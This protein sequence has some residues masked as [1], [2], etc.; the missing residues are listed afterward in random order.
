MPV[1]RKCRLLFGP[2]RAP[3]LHVGDVAACL[4]RDGDVRIKGWSEGRIPWPQGVPGGGRSRPTLLVDDE[5]ARAVRNESA[6]AVKF[7]WGV[8]KKSLWRWRKALGV[9]RT[10]SEGSRR[11]IQAAA[12]LGAQAV[13]E[14]EF[15][16]AEREQRRQTAVRLDLGKHLLPHA[17]YHGPRWTAEE[18]ALLSTLPDEDVAARIGR[19]ALAVSIMRR[20]LGIPNA[21]D[22]RK[23]FQGGG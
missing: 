7:W 3:I 4:Y 23:R 19:T 15:T 20:R 17:G 2:Y 5:L 14:R 6:L 11:L 13:S 1:P 12:K 10:D 9:G 16:P 21:R 22:R 18:L 8:G